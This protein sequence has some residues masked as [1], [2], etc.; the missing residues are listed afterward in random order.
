MMNQGPL[1]LWT[2]PRAR[3]TAFE[4]SV[5]QLKDQVLVEHEHYS[6][7]FFYSAERATRISGYLDKPT[8]ETARGYS[9]ITTWLLRTVDDGKRIFSKDMAYYCCNTTVSDD[10]DMVVKVNKEVIDRLSDFGGGF[11]FLIRNPKESIASLDKQQ[12]RCADLYP[13][14]MEEE[15]G[16]IELHCMYV[17]IRDVLKL[18]TVIV[19]ANDVVNSPEKVLPL[20]CEAVGLTFSEAMLNWVDGD[21]PESWSAWTGWHEEATNS[22]SFAKSTG[23][24]TG[25]SN[26]GSDMAVGQEGASEATIVSSVSKGT[27][28]TTTADSAGAGAGAGAGGD[29][30]SNSKD[31][32]PE[33][34]RQ[35]A[36]NMQKALDNC[37]AAYEEMYNDRIKA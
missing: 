19:D 6:E 4:Q 27:G 11:A 14:F 10:N 5:Y 32:T 26:N 35:R 34:E 21:V 7:A 23:T 13:T 1:I 16:I 18:P 8:N 31:E 20:F 22:T 9:D 29:D 24:G 12:R 30:I 37:L 17:Y 33:I 36:I 25:T 3:S 15:V 28:T 2:H